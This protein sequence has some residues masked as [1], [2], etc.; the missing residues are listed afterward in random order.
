MNAHFPGRGT[1][2]PS[3]VRLADQL[4]ELLFRSGELLALVDEL[5]RSDPDMADRVATF[6]KATYERSDALMTEITE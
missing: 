2:I 3:R 4:G 1:F 5:R 6:A